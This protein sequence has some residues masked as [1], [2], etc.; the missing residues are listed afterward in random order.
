MNFA[1][2]SSEPR[3]ATFMKRLVIISS[4]GGAAE[5]RRLSDLA[6]FFGVSAEMLSFA[7]SSGAASDLL[8]RIQPGPCSLAMHHKTLSRMVAAAKSQDELRQRFAVRFAEIF[9]YGEP[10]PA[11]QDK[12][13]EALTGGVLRG[14]R[15]H[16]AQPVRYAFPHTAKEFSAQLAGQSLLV[17]QEQTTA[18]LEVGPENASVQTILTA[19]E[20]P[21]FVRIQSSAT[22]I[23]LA[24]GQ[25]P[26]L[27]RPLL[28]DED[29]ETGC[30]P[31]L[32]PLIF[33]R[34]CFP[35]SCWHGAE[36][37]ARLIIDDPTLTQHYGALDF[38]LLKASM[39]RMGYG[40]SVAFIPWNYWRTS[41]RAAGQMLAPG[42]NLSVCIHGCD[43]TNHEFQLGSAAMLARKAALGIERMEKLRQRTRVSFEDVMVFPQG[44]FSKASIPGLRA[45]N[46]LAAVNTTCFP[47]DYQPNDLHLADFLLPAITRFD[48]FPLFQRRYPRSAFA[49]ALDLF[50]GKPALL[51]EHHEYFRDRCRA[52]EEFVAELQ[53]IEPNLSWPGLAELAARSRQER[54]GE[55]GAVE[56]RFFTRRFR[57]T[58]NEGGSGSYRLFKFEPDP[59][60]VDRVLIDSRSVAFGFEQGDLQ[61]EMQAEAGQVKAI[62]IVDRVRPAPPIRSFGS[63]HNARVLLRRGLSEFR[64]NTL[65]HHKVL[66]QIARRCV[67]ALKAKGEA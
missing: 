65:S 41:R 35:E 34:A 25:M 48:G 54:R 63:G 62:E 45:A 11:E 55:N 56:I 31:I 57:Y 38:D 3:K 53:G 6:D 1:S 37:A 19:N 39:L 44:Q 21:I 43:H 9:L 67:Q 24:A 20:R 29:W 46:F 30:I 28:R 7:P 14:L 23:F 2:G 27:R 64:D 26:D 18:S 15:L 59:G 66:L 49:S 13:L 50:L 36:A 5:D 47:I 10:A 51:V 60:A 33:L 16:P 22:T 58:A 17:S 61:F 12:A 40:A 52:M 8:G 4:P 42:A 32:P